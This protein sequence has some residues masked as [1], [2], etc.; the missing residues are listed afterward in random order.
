MMK[1]Y[2]HYTHSTPNLVSRRKGKPV[3]LRQLAVLRYKRSF[4]G[5]DIVLRQ[6]Q[7]GK[8]R[9]YLST[10]ALRKECVVEH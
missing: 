7:R 1:P 8:G 6:W 3:V 2:L 10:I 9:N 5:F 4:N